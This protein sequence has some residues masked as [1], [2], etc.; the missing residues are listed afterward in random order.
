MGDLKRRK[1]YNF[2]QSRLLADSWQNIFFT[3]QVT[4]NPGN[5]AKTKRLGGLGE[6]SQIKMLS[7]NFLKNQS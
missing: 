5:V 4:Q 6:I 1:K 7:Q 2:S 3:C